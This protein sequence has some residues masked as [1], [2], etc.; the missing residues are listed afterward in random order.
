MARCV[1]PEDGTSNNYSVTNLSGER[2]RRHVLPLRPLPHK[3][4]DLGQGEGDGRAALK[5]FSSSSS[6]TR[7]CFLT[8]TCHGTQDQVSSAWVEMSASTGGSGGNGA[9]VTT[10]SQRGGQ[11]TPREA[12]TLTLKLTRP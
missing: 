3:M 4:A 5:I 8:H 2:P 6:C 12:A 10:R 11:L 7:K 9:R 1:P